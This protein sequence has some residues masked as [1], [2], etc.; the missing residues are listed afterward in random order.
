MG[1]IE[2]EELINKSPSARS[3]NKAG[4]P[5]GTPGLVT[6]A[7]PARSRL[8][9]WA[10]V[11]QVRT[12]RATDGEA[13]P[14]TPA[15]PAG[16]DRLIGA[17]P[18]GTASPV[19]TCP[20]TPNWQRAP[21]CT[22]AGPSRRPFWMDAAVRPRESSAESRNRGKKQPPL[23]RKRKERKREEKNVQRAQ[24]THSGVPGFQGLRMGSLPL[25][26]PAGGRW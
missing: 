14:P 12:S 9:S 19:P 10:C 13:L 16:L 7:C 23:K 8:C 2:C 15:I 21:R 6:R 18:G 20:R 3:A 26:F 11:P 22:K 25:S 1:L 5:G 4:C 24:G 17:A